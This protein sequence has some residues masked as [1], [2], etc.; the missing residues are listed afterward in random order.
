MCLWFFWLWCW[1]F[2][3][4]LC[5][6]ETAAKF[7]SGLRPRPNLPVLIFCYWNSVFTLIELTERAKTETEIFGLIE[8]PPL[9]YSTGIHELKL[10][11]N[12]LNNQ[13][14]TNLH[15]PNK[16]QRTYNTQIDLFSKNSHNRDSNFYENRT[17]NIKTITLFPEKKT[18]TLWPI[19]FCWQF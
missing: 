12:I 8:Y 17:N 16:I 18:I 6:Y 7:R 14:C 2:L 10:L 3:W 15:F 19:T 11:T 13:P 4:F 1:K 9:V 5:I